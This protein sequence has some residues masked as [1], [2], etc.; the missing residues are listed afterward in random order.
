MRDF[1]NNIGARLLR[2]LDPPLDI[3]NDCILLSYILTFDA[4]FVITLITSNDPKRTT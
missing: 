2:P 4:L 3:I 1:Q